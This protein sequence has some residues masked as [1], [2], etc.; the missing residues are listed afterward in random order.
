LLSLDER[1]KFV[2]DVKKLAQVIEKEL[3]SEATKFRS[4]GF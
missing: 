3:T 4:I 1:K 2:N